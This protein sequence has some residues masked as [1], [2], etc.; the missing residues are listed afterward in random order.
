MIIFRRI[1]AYLLVIAFLPTALAAALVWSALNAF[2]TGPLDKAV[3]ASRAG[4]RLPAMFAV[5][6]SPTFG[7]LPLQPKGFT[8]EQLVAEALPPPRV[9]GLLDELVNGNL[10]YIRGESA[11][12]ASLD[13]SSVYAGFANALKAHLP[14]AIGKEL[15]GSLQSAI[16]AQ[17]LDKGLVIPPDSFKQAKDG[18]AIVL[19]T[20]YAALAALALLLG[21][22]F[23]VA[24]HG[25]RSRLK[26]AGLALLISGILTGIFAAAASAIVGIAFTQLQN[27]PPG[28]SASGAAPGIQD[29]PPDLLAA[30]KDFGISLAGSL[31]ARLL[32]AAAVFAVLG[33]ACLISMATLRKKTQ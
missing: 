27:T 29:M 33:I 5:Q 3:A 18:Y 15:T 31:G 24:P 8:A 13:L 16:A 21:L 1:I 2:E 19:M 22:I 6:L 20:A 17:G 12:P 28:G 4:E 26:Y 14:A 30:I 7:K 32:V 23:L 11:T 9:E 25:L 10:A